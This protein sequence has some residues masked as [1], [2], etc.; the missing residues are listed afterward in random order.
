MNFNSLINEEYSHSA[1]A[2]IMKSVK[3]HW[4]D[5]TLIVDNP[6]ILMDKSLAERMLRSMVLGRKNY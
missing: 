5:S 3:E 1:Q 4:K 2:A 6:E